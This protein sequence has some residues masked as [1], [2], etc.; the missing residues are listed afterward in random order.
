MKE[1][2]GII[3]GLGPL[4][5]AEFIKTIYEYSLKDNRYEQDTPRLMLYSDP[6]FPD[7]TEAF[8]GKN[9][10][11]L[12]EQMI[13][14]LRYLCRAQVSKIIICCVTFHY[15]LDRLPLFLRE[16]IISL[17]DIIFDEIAEIKRKHLLFCSEGTRHCQVFQSHPRWQIYKDYVVL[18]SK[19]DQKELHRVIYSVKKGGGADFLISCITSFLHKYEVKDFI[20]GC[21]EVHLATKTFDFFANG[22]VLGYIDP[23]IIIANKLAKGML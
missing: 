6:S 9:E 18:L 4:A 5:S 3:G 8:L 1:I 13:A 16:K 21:T 11:V 23:L 7:R 10:N 12:L 2:I 22:H 19:E 15:L 17:V 20:S 14:A